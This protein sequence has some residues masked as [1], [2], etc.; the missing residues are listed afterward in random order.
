MGETVYQPV[1]AT[2]AHDADLKLETS[3]PFTSSPQ[4]TTRPFRRLLSSRDLLSK[5]A[6]L[7]YARHLLPSFLQ[8][9]PAT[10]PRPGGPGG[11]NI[12]SLDGLRGLACLCVVNQHFTQAFTR[13]LFWNGWGQ[14]PDDYWLAE[15]PFIK[16]FWA[17]SAQVFTFL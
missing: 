17:G 16:V 11:F 2:D 7:S 6:L 1:S 14:S 9:Q 8:R 13:R 3:E 4:P 15:A 10:K 12:D 5:R